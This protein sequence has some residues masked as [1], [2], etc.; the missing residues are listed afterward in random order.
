MKSKLRSSSAF[1]RLLNFQ[2]NRWRDQTDYGGTRQ[3]LEA[4]IKNRHHLEVTTP[5][6]KQL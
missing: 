5:G 6:L 4:L 3:E 1:L 2:H